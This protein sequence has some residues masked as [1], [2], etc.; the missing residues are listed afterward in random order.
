[1][2]IS[3]APENATRLPK[4]QQNLLHAILINIIDLL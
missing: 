4:I 2:S 3:A 1:M